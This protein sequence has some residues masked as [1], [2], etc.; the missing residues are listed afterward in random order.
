MDDLD[1]LIEW[2][3][4]RNIV[5]HEVDYSTCGGCHGA[6]F[7]RVKKDGKW[8]SI[9]ER[10]AGTLCSREE[11]KKE[12]MLRQQYE[13][14]AAMSQKRAEEAEP[15]EEWKICGC[16]S[17]QDYETKKA[18]GYNFECEQYCRECSFFEKNG[19]ECNG[20][21]TLQIHDGTISPFPP[22]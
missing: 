4:S 22:R 5:P 21:W 7:A 20:K 15:I 18:T 10:P 17:A 12:R 11:D 9:C 16:K 14:D 2:K 1:D 8:H 13:Y 19:G 6:T 3:R